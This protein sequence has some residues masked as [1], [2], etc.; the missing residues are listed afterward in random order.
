MKKIKG[1]VLALVFALTANAFA[2][3]A[4]KGIIV[5][6]NN[7]DALIGAAVA[8]EG[9]TLGAMTDVEGKFDIK[10]PNGK[11]K[12]IFSYIGYSNTTKEITATGST[13]DLGKIALD[14]DAVGLKEISVVASIAVDRK[15]PVAVSTIQPQY[16]AEKLGTQEFPEILK[17]TPGV[18]VTKGG[19]AFGDSRINLRGFDSRNVAVLVNGVPVNDM[20]NGTVYWSNW[21]GMSDATRTM[22]VQRGLGASK[23]AVPSVGGTINIL[24]RTT[25]AKKG[26]EIIS[27]VGNDN[28][29]KYGFTLSTGK[30][31]DGWAST[32]SVSTTEGDGYVDG[33]N[34]KA[35]SY[36]FSLSKKINDEHLLS[37][38]VVGAPQWHNQR[39][40]E[41][42]F[43]NYKNSDR[44]LRYNDSWGYKDGELLNTA[45]NFYHKPQAFLTHYWTISPE[46]SVS[47]V[48]Y[49]STGTGG[50][51]GTYG[52]GSS[53]FANYR[54]DGKV[55]FDRIVDENIANGNKGSDAILRA[56]VN[57][58][59]WYGILSSAKYDMQ[60]LTVTAG[61][62]AR[63]YKGEHYREIT[64][65]LG[66]EFYLDKD[67]DENNPNKIARVGD[68]IDYYNDG[69]VTWG[70]F[71]ATGEYE[72]DNLTA[73][74]SVA[75]STKGYRRIDYFNYLDSDDAQ[76]TDWQNFLGYS[77]KAGANYNIDDMQNVFLNAGYFER[78][79]DFRSVFLNYQNDVNDGAENEK[80]TSIELG[81]GFKSDFVDVKLN[82][83]HTRWM[84]KA[85]IKR[86]RDAG[87]QEIVANILGLD[88]IHQGV[89]LEVLSQVTDR[90]RV[91]G[92]LSYGD[93]RNGDDIKGVKVFDDQ[94]NH[95]GT[96]DL[97]IKDTHV[98]D[99]AQT[100][101]ALG[102]DYE[103][104]KDVKIGVD[105]NYYD[106][107]YAEY[108]A[109][110]RDDKE[111]YDGVDVE[112]LSDY[113]V[114]RANIKYN[115][116]I[117][118]LK[119]SMYGNV[120][121]LLDTEYIAEKSKYGVFM[122]LGRT[123][124]VGLKVR[125]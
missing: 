9:S 91:T 82:A 80:I 85:L 35:Y 27:Y 34:F 10:V 100:T 72:M 107:L 53:K 111:K 37:F 120:D 28:F 52:G 62:D 13:I 1:L 70:G 42:A 117:A 109:T 22:Q 19:G 63:Y 87:G 95:I 76:T 75:A 78:Q 125:F 66:G 77:V 121:N 50:G 12:L 103:I 41:F 112:E 115:F 23:V 65:L 68:K 38:S 69:E 98:G 21:A 6:A 108:D 61:I 97:Y 113:G 30:T 15:T 67:Q 79:P 92:M 118:G 14:E 57:N 25:D 36:F 73:F 81:Y 74:V 51:T 16:I 106:R 44:G 5:D 18:Y 58:H 46:L 31:E 116:E 83:Y 33:T 86:Y 84:D 122:G 105:Y 47:N 49:G 32:V 110:D 26:G 29:K 8:V 71:F 39:K 119:A 94:Q 7:G 11:H 20:E 48:L 93:W 90:L 96:V 60:N 102:V 88:Q 104:L 3:T 123:W 17:S 24:T 43:E 45:K 99:A 55:D 101:A 54:R 59:S 114:L 64:D 56:S 40:Y 4:V 89:E 2:Q 124:S